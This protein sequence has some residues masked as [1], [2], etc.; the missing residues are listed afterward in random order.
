MST[1]LV[2]GRLAPG[3][4]MRELSPLN[5]ESC[6]DRGRGQDCK[7]KQTEAKEMNVVRKVVK[8]TK[9]GKWKMDSAGRLRR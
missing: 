4:G 9:M 1:E 5:I 7:F 6:R 3:Q 2:V 8:E